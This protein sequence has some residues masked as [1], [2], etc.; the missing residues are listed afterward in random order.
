MNSMHVTVAGSGFA[1]PTLAPQIALLPDIHQVLSNNSNSI[2]NYNSY[3]NQTG[4]LN[5]LPAIPNNIESNNSS[6]NKNQTFLT[7]RYPQAKTTNT[8]IPF[9]ITATSFPAAN[10]IATAI[11]KSELYYG[12]NNFLPKPHQKEAKSFVSM[13]VTKSDS[14]FYVFNNVTLKVRS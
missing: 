5:Y 3:D 6:S 7:T 14:G 11:E 4:L 8:T 10:Q 2:S 1:S 13:M 9:P 12:T